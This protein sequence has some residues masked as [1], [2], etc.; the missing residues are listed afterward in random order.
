MEMSCS[1]LRGSDSADLRRGPEI[2]IFNHRAQVILMQGT[3]SFASRTAA[4]RVAG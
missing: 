1:P 2:I 3:G 4:V